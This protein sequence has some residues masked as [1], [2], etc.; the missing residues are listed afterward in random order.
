[1]AI[2]VRRWCKDNP[3]VRRETFS[4]AGTRRK[5]LASASDSD[6]G[7]SDVEI[8]NSS[9]VASS[10]RAREVCWASE[11]TGICCRCG[12]TCIFLAP[13]RGKAERQ[14]R[15]R[16]RGSDSRLPYAGLTSCSLMKHIVYMDASIHP[17]Y[18][19]MARETE[20]VAMRLRIPRSVA[21]YVQRC[22]FGH[23]VSVRLWLRRE[24]EFL[25]GLGGKF[26]I[27]PS[28]H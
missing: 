13:P 14:L 20:K 15:R 5:L 6:V 27:K 3:E 12:T 22:L 11:K 7:K 26:L 9:G 19:T 4:I 8:T 18:E 25:D 28:R 17:V 1:M 21:P 10:R 2:G 24:A 16:K 23:S